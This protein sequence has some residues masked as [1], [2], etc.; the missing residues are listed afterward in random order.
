MPNQQFTK[1]DQQMDLLLSSRGFQNIIS[2]EKD[3]TFKV[4]LQYFKLSKLQAEFISPSVS[5]L[6]R[7]DETISEFEI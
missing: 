3:F 1:N 4:N 5:N 2:K 6:I 7:F